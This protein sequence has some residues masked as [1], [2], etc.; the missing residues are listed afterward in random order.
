[1]VAKTDEFF[2]AVELDFGLNSWNLFSQ[3]LDTSLE[4]VLTSLTSLL[5]WMCTLGMPNFFIVGHEKW[6]CTLV[7]AVY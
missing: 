3:H 5:P 4:N 7:S 1:M 6:M 2:N